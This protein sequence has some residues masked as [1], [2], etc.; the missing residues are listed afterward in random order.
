MTIT[1]TLPPEDLR[2]MARNNSHSEAYINAVRDAESSGYPEASVRVAFDFGKQ[3]SRA[4]G[5]QR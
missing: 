2:G 3:H 4:T 1:I 5:D